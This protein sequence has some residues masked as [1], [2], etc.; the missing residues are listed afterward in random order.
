MGKAVFQVAI[1]LQQVELALVR[2]QGSQSHPPRHI[3]IGD[4]KQ[5]LAQLLDL[6]ATVDKL[7]LRNVHLRLHVWWLF[8]PSIIKYRI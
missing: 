5:I 6:A 4:I 8:K 7:T 2:R 1:N 3:F